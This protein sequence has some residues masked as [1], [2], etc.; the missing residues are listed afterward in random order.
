[1]AKM[2]RVRVLH[3]FVIGPGNYAQIG[4]EMEMPLHQAIADRNA[5]AV[6]FIGPEEQDEDPGITK[7]PVV[8]TRDP[9]VVNRDPKIQK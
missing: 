1:M 6:E 3:G 5:G 2:Q 7:A 9:K 8:Q 4:D